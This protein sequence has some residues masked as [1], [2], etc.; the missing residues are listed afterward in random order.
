MPC[1]AATE[2]PV[3]RRNFVALSTHG[4]TSVEFHAVKALTE[5]V[6]SAVAKNSD[7]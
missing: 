2:I 3:S 1:G 7:V 5:P 4:A 6:N